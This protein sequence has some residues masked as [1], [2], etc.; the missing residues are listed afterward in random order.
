MLKRGLGHEASLGA[1]P[2]GVCA[3]FVTAYAHPG[4]QARMMSMTVPV[5]DALSAFGADL[6]RNFAAAS[7]VPA[8]AEDQ[9]KAPVKALLEEI[10]EGVVARTEASSDEPGVRPDLGV[11]VGGALTGHVE[12]KA[13]GKGADATK[14]KDEHDRAQFKRL[15]G[16]P[17]LLYTDGNDWA[18][19][20]KGARVGNV[21]RASGD[22]TTQGAAAYTDGDCAA[23]DLVLRDFLGWEPIVP[24]SPKALAELLAPLTRLLREGVEVALASPDSALAHLAREWR[25]VFFPDADDA[26]FADA[27]AQTVMYA[28]LLARVEGAAKLEREA[29]DRLDEKHGLLAQVLRVLAQPQARKEVKAP[30]EL[31]ERTIEAVDPAALQTGEGEKDVWLYFYEDFLA[32]YDPKLRKQS[33]VYYTP[34]EVVQAQVK[35]VAELLRERFDRDLG[36]IPVGRERVERYGLF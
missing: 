29:A 28:L 9:L 1:G 15:A 21:V 26:Q 35:L 5:R 6:A 24:R 32:A 31:L 25:D 33:G 4:R 30:A 17:N 10:A 2:D 14:F 11:S 13:P 16:H 20:R 36:P 27:Y 18:L 12:L 34:A 22:V 7:T 3:G 23:L 8:Q 19:Y